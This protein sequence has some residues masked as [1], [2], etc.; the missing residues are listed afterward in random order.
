MSG[1]NAEQKQDNV[2]HFIRS[3]FD[4]SG[5]TLLGIAQLENGLELGTFGKFLDLMI[6][7][8]LQGHGVGCGLFAAEMVQDFVLPDLLALLDEKAV[9]EGQAGEENG[10]REGRDVSGA[11]QDGATD[12]VANSTGGE[13]EEV[14][15]P[16]PGSP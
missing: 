7:F 11:D 3:L 10:D 8:V 13:V 1:I 5:D 16:Y 9:D 2:S 15:Q 12:G 6:I 14:E 4:S